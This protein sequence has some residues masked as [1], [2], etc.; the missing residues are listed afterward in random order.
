MTL[1]TTTPAAP[2]LL[3]DEP[4]EFVTF[5]FTHDGAGELTRR[6]FVQALGAGLLV[7]VTCASA[8]AQ[9]RGGRGQGGQRGGR[10]GGGGFRGSGAK[11]V[12][13]RVHLGR[14]GA[15]TVMTGKVEGG[16]GARAELTQA[17]AE[18]LRVAPDRIRLLMADTDL[19][20]DDGVTAGSRS[21][22]STVPSVRQGCAAARNL[23]ASLAA[24][25]WSTDQSK[26]DVRDGKV[27]DPAGGR[28]ITYADLA[29]AD[30]AAALFAGPVPQDVALAPAAEWKVMGKSL[31]RPNGRDVV[32]GAHAFPSD[33]RRP[34]MLY[35]KVLRPPSYNAKL[36]SADLEA[37]RAMKGVVAVR[38]G[39]FVAVASPTTFAADDA[40]AS[41]ADKAKWQ[42]A[43][44]PSSAELFTH[45]RNHAREFPP[46]PV[47]DDASAAKRLKQSYEVAYV[48]HAPMEPRAAV[49]EWDGAG[50]LT[51]W[52]ATQNP[53]GVRGELARA[54]SIDP[55]KVH[56]IVP[57]FGGGFGGKHTGECAV[58]AARIAKAAQKPVCLRWT[59]EE[60]FT[61]AYFRPA[62]L[63]DAEAGLAADR[64]GDVDHA[65]RAEVGPGELLLARPDQLD[66][67]VDGAGQPGGLDRRVAKVLAAVGRACVGD[68]HA[69]G[70]LRQPERRRQLGAHAERPLRACPHGHPA[71]AP[72][73]HGR[74]RLQRGVRDIGDCIG[75]RQSQLGRST[76]RR[77][78]ALL[79]P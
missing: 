14:D 63:I 42:P 31:P 47:S 25:R 26:L 39:S 78:V 23:L 56:V 6:S 13:A 41:V 11:N 53:F 52:T 34:G 50:K 9:D 24:R 58:E 18:E 64:A 30:D 48:Q 7:A 32:T 59:R 15:I 36:D 28:E 60:E 55:E 2:D 27:L 74:A 40:L 29:G 5:E 68:D 8:G 62:A 46:N 49:A 38:D 37:A 44:H 45:L 51:V 73:R 76:R 1:N 54:F 22:P 43:D 57:D 67:R 61:W 72:I 3:E 4:L 33:V 35:G 75:L 79:V 16:Q 20:P 77:D 21:T 12:A 69:D 66:R 65:G 10:G 71:V 70:C 17:A 19:T